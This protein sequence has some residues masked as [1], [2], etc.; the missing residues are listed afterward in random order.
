MARYFGTL[1]MTVPPSAR[2][3]A[4][5]AGVTSAW[6]ST[7][8]ISSVAVVSG[9]CRLATPYTC[10]RRAGRSCELTFL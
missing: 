5:T 7:I 10:A 2:M 1:L 6:M 9:A 3:R 8:A 4:S